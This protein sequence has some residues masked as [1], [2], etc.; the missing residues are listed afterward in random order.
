[1]GETGDKHSETYLLLPNEGLY[2]ERSLTTFDTQKCLFIY[3][4]I[5]ALAYLVTHMQNTILVSDLAPYTRVHK[6][7]LL[8][9]S[10]KRGLKYG[11]SKRS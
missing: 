2:K 11:T 4:F 6:H 9:E 8:E 1:M 7:L 5:Y 10:C 3:V